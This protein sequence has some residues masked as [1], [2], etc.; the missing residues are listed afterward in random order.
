MVN[1]D[2]AARFRTWLVD[3]TGA[4]NPDGLIVTLH[5]G[6]RLSERIAQWRT[7]ETFG[8]PVPSPGPSVNRPAWCG[9][10]DRSTRLAVAHDHEG[11]EYVR[12]CP[13][14]NPNTGTAPAGAGAAQ[15]IA[16]TAATVDRTPGA[17]REAFLA[18]RAALPAGT[19]RRTTT[20]GTVLDIATTRA[21]QDGAL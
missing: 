4:T 11:H 5:T 16:I 12:R 17:G 15:A 13:V 1:P 18:A 6:G 10:C 8:R 9:E 3:A 2:E 21:T 14:C 20:I 7:A 19:P